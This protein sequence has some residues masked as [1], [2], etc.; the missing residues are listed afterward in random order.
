MHELGV[1]TNAVRTVSSV[2]KQN[3]VKIVKF[4]TLQIGAEST[5]VPAFMEKLF[6]AA[7]ENYPILKH[8]ELR[9]E[10]VPGNKLIIKEIGY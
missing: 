3:G 1:L 9:I 10:V 4:M 7:K 6:P 8:A 2:A 5:F